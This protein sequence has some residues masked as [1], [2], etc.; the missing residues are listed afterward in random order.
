MAAAGE[1][2]K[3][4]RFYVGEVKKNLR[5]GYGFYVY[6]NS[7][8]RY[9]GEWKLGKKNGN[10]K[11]VMKDGSYYE[12][13]FKD[14]EINGNGLRYW[15]STGN[16]YSGQFCFG[17]LHGHGV[18]QYGK[19]GQYEGEFSYGLRDGHG[20]LFDKEGNAYQGSFHKN[21]KHGEG[22]IAYSN[23][24]VYEGDW[25]LDQRQGHGVLRSADSSIYEGQWR[26]DLF[27]GHGTMIHSSGIIYEGQW[28]NGQPACAATKIVIEGG[29]VLE[30]FQDS[31]FNVEVQLQDD[32]GQLIANENGRLLKISAGVRFVEN[33][34]RSSSSALLRLI[35]DMEEKPML[36]PFGFECVNYPLMEVSS[37]SEVT[38]SA[39]PNNEQSEVTMMDSSIS[40]SEVE[41][42]IELEATEGSEANL[43]NRNGLSHPPGAEDEWLTNPTNQRVE[44]GRATF[45][46]LMLAPPLKSHLL[47]D[48]LSVLEQNKLSKRQPG[49]TH[50]D[51]TEKITAL[52]E[53]NGDTRSYL[54]HQLGIDS[55]KDT[56]EGRPPRTGDYVIIIQ[57]VTNPPFLGCTLAPAFALLRVIPSKT[58]S[59][60]TS[61]K[62][63]NIVKSK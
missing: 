39:M 29:D 42:Q 8:F 7:F 24:D 21:K 12:G 5:D 1:M 26:N 14:G 44:A 63:S 38:Y 9:E 19:G 61:K 3:S 16:T 41:S 48:P 22:Q 18:M 4:S 47:P 36:T 2:R 52:Q 17:E 54:G 13:E 11:L 57:E 31:F 35:E 49:K 6:P 10:G 23:G 27:N 55:K 33:S 60:R 59:N 37:E 25:I 20:C 15:A 46:N 30:V 40:K 58:K 51:K 32:E 53:K 50:L 43:L 28:I 45:R 34:V 62:E 56:A